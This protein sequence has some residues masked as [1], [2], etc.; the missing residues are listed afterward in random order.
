MKFKANG[1]WFTFNV[2]EFNSILQLNFKSIQLNLN[3]NQ[4]VSNVIQ[5][6]YAN[7]T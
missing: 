2:F 7:E 6:F 1:I 5:S 4:V 3:A